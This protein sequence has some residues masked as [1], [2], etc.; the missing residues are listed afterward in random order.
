MSSCNQCDQ[1]RGAPEGFGIS[2]HYSTGK[3]ARFLI[4]VKSGAA[5]GLHAGIAGRYASIPL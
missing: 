5:R 2:L 1:Q 3:A 4:C